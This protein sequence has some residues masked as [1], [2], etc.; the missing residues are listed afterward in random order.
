LPNV[1]CPVGCTP[2]KIRVISALS[3]LRIRTYVETADPSAGY[4]REIR[5]RPPKRRP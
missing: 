5:E 4:V 3:P 2:L 1:R